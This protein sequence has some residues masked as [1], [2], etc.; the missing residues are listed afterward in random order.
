M[1]ACII[2]ILIGVFQKLRS[3]ALHPL[4]ASHTAVERFCGAMPHLTILNLS[5]A[6]N[7]DHKNNYDGVLR[8][9]AGNMHHLKYLDISNCTTEPKAIEYL[10][11][12]ENNSVGGCPEL[13]SLFLFNVKSIDVNLL[14]KIILALPKLE[15][16]AHELFVNALVDLTEEE[17]DVDT[18]RALDRLNSWIIQQ[19]KSLPLLRYDI[20]T[21]SPVF[22]RLNNNINT[23]EILINKWEQKQSAPVANVLMSLTKLKNMTLWGISEARTHMLPVL[24][25]I[26]DRLQFLNLHDKSR[27]L[28]LQDIM[29]TCPKLVELT[30]F[31]NGVKNLQ[32]NGIH[33]NYDHTEMACMQP[34][35]NYL[36]EIDI[37][38]MD[39]QMCSADMLTALLQSPGLNII[40]L[41]YLEAMSDDVMFNVLSSPG[42]V[43][44]SKVHR[45]S[46]T[47]CSM[48]TAAPFIDWLTKDNCTLQYMEFNKCEKVDGRILGAVAEKCPRALII[49]MINV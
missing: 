28:S 10:L 3:L 17:M 5:R 49:I 34:V 29:R 48:I 6:D 2:I 33:I 38:N 22:Q 20:L 37:V 45:F 43:A 9:I 27:S 35:L 8:A 32:E 39:K 19:D 23:V 41:D 12:T 15:S 14:K 7:N 1:N 11:P 13:V 46:L 31:Y 30:L 24:E 4:T 44:L 25:A 42:G 16:L 47:K 26:G 36:T 18:A 40:H 21:K